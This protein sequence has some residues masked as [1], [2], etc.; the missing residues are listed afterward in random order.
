MLVL[1][2]FSASNFYNWPNELGS[3]LNAL[4]EIFNPFNDF[5]DPKLYGNVWS[6]WLS[7]RLSLIKDDNYPNDWGNYFILVLL[8]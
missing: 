7:S 3:C 5:N 8:I 2:I 1:V 4:P 6:E